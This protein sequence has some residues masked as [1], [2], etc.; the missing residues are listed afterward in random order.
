MAKLKDRGKWLVALAL[1]LSCLVLCAALMIPPTRAEDPPKKTYV[2][3]DGFTNVYERLNAEGN[4]FT[5]KEF[6]YASGAAADAPEKV[7]NAALKKTGDQ[8]T[9]GIDGYKDAANNPEVRFFPIKANGTL[10]TAY[11]EGTEP[12]VNTAQ[13]LK[14][15][16]MIYEELVWKDT[17][18]TSLEPRKFVYSSNAA[19]NTQRSL[20]AAKK[21]DKYYLRLKDDIYIAVVMEGAAVG[22]LDCNDVI[23]KLGTSNEEVLYPL[24]PPVYKYAEVKDRKN[25]YEMLDKDGKPKSPREYIYSTKAP[26]DGK[27]PPAQSQQALPKGDSFYVCLLEGSGIFVA[28]NADDGTLNFGK[29]IWWGVDKKFDTKDDLSTSVKE[30]GGY[31][32]WLQGQ[33]IWQMIDGLFNP[34]YTTTTAP[35]TSSST[36]TAAPVYKYA[37][38]EN[39]KN[40]YEVL[41]ADGKSQSP[42]E[43]LYSETA[44]VNGNPPPTKARTAFARGAYFYVPLVEDSGIFLAVNS[45]D[46]S[47]NYS[48]AVWWGLDRKFGTADDFETSVKVE[49]DL[50]Y[51]LTANGIWERIMGIVNPTQPTTTTENPLLTTA[52]PEGPPKTGKE[53]FSPGMAVCLAL[54]FMGCAYCGYQALRRRKVY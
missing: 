33:G 46:G 21:G 38:V 22:T 23:K 1:C 45:S 15:A 32:Y 52:D 37:P 12:E 16:G 24:P 19:P 17:S 8:Y 3:V 2:K 44:P 54:L 43:Y 41:G 18:W 30:D 10:D 53:S 26:E 7:Y 27:A 39:Y 51:W 5:T 47:L 50:Y 28:V 36:V 31:F 11:P 9:I 25:I 42:K 48:N 4:S 40:L 14:I 29:A 34:N 20:P 49:D 6:F 13:Y 35:A